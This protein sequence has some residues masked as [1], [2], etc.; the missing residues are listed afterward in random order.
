MRGRSYLAK[1]DGKASHGAERLAPG[2]NSD[3]GAF[4]RSVGSASLLSLSGVETLL[5]LLAGA[6]E[7][8][9][10]CQAGGTLSVDPGLVELVA[11]TGVLSLCSQIVLTP[12]GHSVR[13][14]GRGGRQSVVAP[15]GQRRA[16]RR[17]LSVL[18]GV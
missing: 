13:V 10:A 3:R 17:P 7:L 18:G 8:A 1:T 5:C 9:Q 4:A 12:G 16:S 15:R 6:F 2:V 11:L 14:E